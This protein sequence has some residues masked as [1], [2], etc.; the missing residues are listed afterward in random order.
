MQE[1]EGIA[2]F[3]EAAPLRPDADSAPSGGE[4]E[5]PINEN[6]SGR[7]PS[8]AGIEHALEEPENAPALVGRYSAGGASYRI[9]SDGSIE[10][11]TDQ[12]AFKFASMSEF[13]AHLADKRA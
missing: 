5:E 11:E 1:V 6:R 13:K 9:F 12:G 7:L 4:A 10:A 3:V 8:L 2:P